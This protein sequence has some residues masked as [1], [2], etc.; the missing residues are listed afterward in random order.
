MVREMGEIKEIIVETRH[1][2]NTLQRN[3]MALENTYKVLCDL[4][5]EKLRED[6]A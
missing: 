4:V 2:M 3:L 1:A 6:G 5:E